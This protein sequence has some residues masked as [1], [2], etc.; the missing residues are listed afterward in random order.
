MMRMNPDK[1]ALLAM[2][3]Q[4][5]ILATLPAPDELISKLAQ[6]I[7]VTR[8]CG[9]RV[10]YVRVAFK[11]EELAAFPTHSAMGQRMNSLGNMVLADASTTQID[12]RLE[13]QPLDIQVRKCRVGPF[14]TTDLHAQLRTTGIDTLVISGIHTSGCV[15]TAV[16]EAHDLDYRVVVLTDCCADPNEAVHEFLI[17]V[18]FPKQALLLRS[19]ELEH[20]WSR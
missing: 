18:I 4:P 9:A 20:H 3:F 11:P 8:R 16:R 15:L 10:G 2:D 12:A 19:S 1:T 6:A 5:M 7:A 13:P 14:S 17:N